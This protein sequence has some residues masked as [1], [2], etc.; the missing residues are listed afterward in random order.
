MTKIIGLTGGIGSGKTTVS[1]MFEK[2]GVPIFNSDLEAR[3]IMNDKDIISKISLLFN[4]IVIDENGLLD[5]KKISNI[6]FK[7]KEKLKE[8]NAIIHPLI[9]SHFNNWLKTHKNKKYVIKETA[10]LFENNGQDLCDATILVTA[11]DEVRIQ[12]VMNR[13]NKSRE[14]VLQV[15]ANQ[16]PETEKMKLANYLIVN[17][18]LKESCEKIY[19]LHKKLN[20]I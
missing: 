4:D 16:M 18:D 9:K 8:L 1:R 2:L 10:I 19:N 12:R 15:M 11:P 14:E 3:L 17:V 5:R 20:I 6:V 7:D 13:D